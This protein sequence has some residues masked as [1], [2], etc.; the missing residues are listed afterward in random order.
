[1][2]KQDLP[3]PPRHG[4][5]GGGGHGRQPRQ[6]QFHDRLLSRTRQ[7]RRTR[8]TGRRRVAEFGW[9]GSSEQA[10]NPHAERCHAQT[11]EVASQASNGMASQQTF[12][13]WPQPRPEKP[14]GLTIEVPTGTCESPRGA[15][16]H[17]PNR[18]WLHVLT[19]LRQRRKV[20]TA[21]SR[22]SALFLALH[23][24]GD[25][26]KSCRRLSPGTAPEMRKSSCFIPF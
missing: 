19:S 22:I 9:A 10:T 18:I 4:Q 2:A 24:C 21:T 20:N 7:G 13:C 25:I 8:E 1:M 11:S 12:L 16:S 26:Q 15:E 5:I 14:L 17:M 6:E 23:N 3:Q